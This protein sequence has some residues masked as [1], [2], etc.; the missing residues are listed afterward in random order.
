V[1]GDSVSL[2]LDGGMVRIPHERIRRSNL[3][4]QPDGSRR[5]S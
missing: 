4:S 5:K 2:A 3:I 1:D